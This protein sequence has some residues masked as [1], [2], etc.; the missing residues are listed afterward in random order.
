MTASRE[1]IV[2][3]NRKME[4]AKRIF[5]ENAIE[6]QTYEREL[7][8]AK[9]QQ[10]AIQNEIQETNAKIKEQEKANS[11]LTKSIEQSSS[12]IERLDSRI[13]TE[14]PRN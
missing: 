3:L 9:T 14:M 5:G 13:G 1:K 7:A 10:I 8:R 2:L 12:E 6:T 4:E 11:E